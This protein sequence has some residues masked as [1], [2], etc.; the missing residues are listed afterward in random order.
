MIPVKQTL[1]GGGDAP[2]EKWGDCFRA[3]IASVLEVPGRSLPH[4][5]QGDDETWYGDMQDYLCEQ[6]GFM[7]A[8]VEREDLPW[9]EDDWGFPG[10]WLASVP[11]RNLGEGVTHV[12]VMHG[13]VLV[14]DPAR[15]NQRTVVA[16]E[17][18][19]RASW[20]IAMDPAKTT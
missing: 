2:R 6:F 19:R 3:A 7:L 4:F 1:V 8:D 9:T 20:F 15:R 14:H 10:Y 11:S 17:E 13:S 12:V 18:L 16:F 5:I